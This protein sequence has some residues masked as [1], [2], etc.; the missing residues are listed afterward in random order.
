[1]KPY[2]LLK[3]VFFACIMLI[4]L[5]PVIGFELSAGLSVLSVVASFLPM[6]Q[7]VFGMN[8]TNNESAYQAY[9]RS[10]Q[11]FYNSFIQ[12]FMD[13][14]KP[15]PVERCKAYVEA[16]KL[17]QSE[18]RMEV[19]LTTAATQFLFAVL[20]SDSNTTGVKF[21]TEQRLKPQDTLVCNE[22]KIEIAQTAG[23][24]DVNYPVDTYPNTQHFA[25]AD[26]AALRNIL[27][28]NGSFGILCNGDVVYPYRRLRN[29]LVIPQT[30]QTAAL[31]AGSPN[32][33]IRGAEDAF[34]TMSP[35]IFLI[36]TKG[37][38]PV[39]QLKTALVGTFTN[40]RCILTMSGILAQ[41]STS[42]S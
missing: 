3:S 40:V 22:Y 28:D 34:V 20:P 36:G 17:S 31:G 14:N 6:P 38:Q 13:D 11:V 5:I 37:Y 23:N 29:H 41:N 32:D 21:P 39:I 9:L 24:D 25:A 12:D 7:N 42:N 2:K 33:Q 15:N 16:L 8:N 10:K 27:Y 4:F 1:M 30:Q 35:G 19:S 18:V 26:I